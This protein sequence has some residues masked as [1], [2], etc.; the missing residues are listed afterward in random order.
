MSSSQ[1]SQPPPNSPFQG[2]A[3]MPNGPATNARQYSNVYDYADAGSYNP[4]NPM[5][6]PSANPQVM[7]GMPHR[8]AGAVAHLSNSPAMS[9]AQIINSMFH[10]ND[11]LSIERRAGAG[12]FGITNISQQPFGDVGYDPVTPEE[13]YGRQPLAA[14]ASARGNIADVGQMVQ[15]AALYS[16]PQFLAGVRQDAL[17]QFNYN[18]LT[19]PAVAPNNATSVAS[20]YNSVVR[21]NPQYQQL[22]MGNMTA[23]RLNQYKESG[24]NYLQTAVRLA[25]S[26]VMQG[27]GNLGNSIANQYVNLDPEVQQFASAGIGRVH[28]AEIAG[29][30]LQQTARAELQSE[31]KSGAADHVSYNLAVSD[32]LADQ[33]FTESI[34]EGRESFI[35]HAGLRDQPIPL[36]LHEMRNIGEVANAYKG[37]AKTSAEDDEVNSF[38][39]PNASEGFGFSST[40]K[41]T[42]TG[43][44]NLKA[45]ITA[46]N[47]ATAALRRMSGGGAGG[48]GGGGMGGGGM[49]GGG[50]GGGDDG[51]ISSEEALKKLKG[52]GTVSLQNTEFGVS[53]GFFS[54][55]LTDAQ[56]LE[57]DT[58]DRRRAKFAGRLSR[59]VGGFAGRLLTQSGASQA[60]GT[61]VE[62]Q[63]GSV[64]GFDR[65]LE[66]IGTLRSFAGL[67]AGGELSA[68]Q[69]QA[70]MSNQY[71]ETMLQSTGITSGAKYGISADQMGAILMPLASAQGGG[72]IDVDKTIQAYAAGEDV[73]GYYSLQGQ[74]R[75]GGYGLSAQEFNAAKARGL[76]G[77]VATG[78]ASQLFSAA[79]GI[80]QNMNMGQDLGMLEGRIL[81]MGRGNINRGAGVFSRGAGVFG[82]AKQMLLSPFE[83]LS[84]ILLMNEALGATGSLTGAANRLEQGEAGGGVGAFGRLRRVVGS[85]MAGLLMRQR[86]LSARDVRDLK[87]GDPLTQSDEP[88]FQLAGDRSGDATKASAAL[89]TRRNE[90]IGE[91]YKR[92]GTFEKI[93]D[94]DRRVE[95]RILD[96]LDGNIDSINRL[97]DSV[98]KVMRAIDAAIV[99]AR[100][101]LVMGLNGTNDR[102]LQI[103]AFKAYQYSTGFLR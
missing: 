49:G 16:N 96:R 82:S 62:Q 59:R 41:D 47:E 36:T 9:S 64:F 15:Q 72:P 70:L 3:D 37:R 23:D 67:A 103:S 18:L 40:E 11:A 76:K 56:G 1:N 90:Q 43:V 6:H 74:R 24:E 80:D 89:A 30:L 85:D 32:V 93:L 63:L 66:G 25:S 5:P 42:G 94:A 65:G 44:P 38:I 4:R 26:E 87:A 50:M 53:S 60:G 27:V 61:T 12:G 54:G 10:T 14:A 81:A 100:N 101:L 95:K 71:G 75:M 28:Q 97:L 77:T 78:Y 69:A 29:G 2:V 51:R 102:V 79:S 39:N 20:A 55:L 7:M 48:I 45:F 34:A 17:E 35:T 31:G 22:Q 98:D 13:V 68:L 73:S 21:Q 88:T 33:A 52:A 86:G 58:I 84:D 83:G 91:L 19:G 92:F 99:T 46:L 8:V 57:S